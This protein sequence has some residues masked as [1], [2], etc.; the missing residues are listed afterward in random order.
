MSRECS[1]LGFLI[2]SL[3]FPRRSALFLVCGPCAV[4]VRSLCGLVR[5]CAVQCG[6]VRSCAV[7]P[8]PSQIGTT[9][10]YLCR[11]A[12]RRRCS[13]LT[14]TLVNLQ[15]YL[16]EEDLHIATEAQSVVGPCRKQEA[17]TTAPTMTTMAPYRR[18]RPPPCRPSSCCP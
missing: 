12:E 4:R 16:M 15:F 5:C 13:L 7:F 14:Y 18:R 2:L 8:L 17:I 3:T 9:S 1:N 10:N 6:R 11:V